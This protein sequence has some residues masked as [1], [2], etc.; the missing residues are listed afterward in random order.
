MT[1]AL[2]TEKPLPTNAVSGMMKIRDA[3][4]TDLPAIIKITTPRS[5]PAFPRLNSNRS[6]CKNVTTG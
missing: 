6:R 1:A 4:E 3:R 2:A 5:L